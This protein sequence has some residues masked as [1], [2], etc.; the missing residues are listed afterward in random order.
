MGVKVDGFDKMKSIR[1]H[2]MILCVTEDGITTVVPE[3]L[4]FQSA[5]EQ[6]E[7]FFGRDYSFTPIDLFVHKFC[8]NRILNKNEL[9]H[10]FDEIIIAQ[11]EFEDGSQS[12]CTIS[13]VCAKRDIQYYIQVKTP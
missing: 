7:V 1:T 11:L 3:D 9:V 12:S 13:P 2:N 8:G 10:H 6:S 5:K 4:V